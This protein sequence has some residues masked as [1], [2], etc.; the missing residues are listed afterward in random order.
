MLTPRFSVALAAVGLAALALAGCTAVT[1]PQAASTPTASAPAAVATPVTEATPTPKAAE[2]ESCS[3]LSEVSSTDGGLYWTRR[4]TLRDLGAR[5]FAR[6]EVTVDAEGLP[7]TYTVEADDVMAVVAER[8]CAY[9]TLDSMNHRRDIHPGQVLW[10]TPDPDSPWIPYY[11]PMDAPAGFLQIPYQQ[12]IESAGAAVDAGD[13][14]TVRAI[15]H[16]T[17]KPM[18]TDQGTIAAVQSVVDSGDLD[19][20]RQLFS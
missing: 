20:L 12:A 11:G 18:F 7:V 1:T 19:A 13:V 16:D 9:P 17:L 6:G 4:G 8:L 10:L 5:E 14:D 3:S 2:S 15:W